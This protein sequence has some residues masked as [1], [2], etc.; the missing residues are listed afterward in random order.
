MLGPANSDWFTVDNTTQRITLSPR[1]I[2]QDSRLQVTILG[3]IGGIP[4]NPQASDVFTLFIVERSEELQA[5]IESPLTVQQ[6]FASYMAPVKKSQVVDPS[7]FT[8]SITKITR[9]GMVKIEFSK[10]PS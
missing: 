7:P 8:A 3:M 5:Q 1:K 10:L 2:S 4:T 9:D 6:F